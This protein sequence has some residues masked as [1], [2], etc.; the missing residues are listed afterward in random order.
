MQ[1]TK[2]A[3]AC[4]SLTGDGGRIVIDPGTFTPDAA[5]AVAAAEAVLIT[6]EHFDHFDEKL[7]A[8]ALEARPALRV[9]GPGSVVGRWSARPGQVTEVAA[10]DEF[11]VAGFDVAVYGDL[12]AAIHRDIPRVANVGYLVDGSLYHPGDAYHAPN[13]TVDTLLL[14]TSG[15]WTKLGE[16]VDYVREVAPSRLVQ[17]HEVM[18]SGLGQQSMTRFLDPDGLTDVGLTIVPPGDTI[19]V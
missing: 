4:V 18:L 8:E 7:I 19:S 2:H 10:G 13:A 11:A 3:H 6:H 16:A 1:L 14:P 5:E 9:Y 17:I 12:H 15:P